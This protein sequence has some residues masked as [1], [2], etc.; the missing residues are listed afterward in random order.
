VEAVRGAFCLR[1]GWAGRA[2]RRLLAD[3]RPN[4][5]RLP[6]P[7]SRIGFRHLFVVLKWIRDARVGIW[8]VREPR[9]DRG[10]DRGLLGTS[11]DTLCV[12]GHTIRAKPGHRA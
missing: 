12:H 3:A 7:G 10:A 9:G 4:P 11:V 6:C 8:D 5:C 2:G 1:L